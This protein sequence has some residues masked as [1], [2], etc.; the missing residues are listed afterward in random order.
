MPQVP[1]CPLERRFGAL[2]R[3]DSNTSPD[4]SCSNRLAAYSRRRRH[5]QLC[6]RS[7]S[8]F[9]YFTIFI[10]SSTLIQ[11]NSQRLNETQSLEC[12]ESQISSNCEIYTLLL[13]KCSL[14]ELRTDPTKLLL[15]G[16]MRVLREL[17]SWQK[18]VRTKACSNLTAHVRDARL[19]V[20]QLLLA[21]AGSSRKLQTASLDRANLTGLLLG[22]LAGW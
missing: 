15:A 12:A 3:F 2:K 21:A 14:I 22:W 4:P 20:L 8:R 1:S 9:K 7:S 5:G 17:T 16:R 18:D 13:N 11:S 10:F 6:V 19:Q